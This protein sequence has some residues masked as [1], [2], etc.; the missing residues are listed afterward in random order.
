MTTQD[1][2]QTPT[3]YEIQH[4]A[5]VALA[6]GYPLVRGEL[7]IK[8]PNMRGCRF[9][10]VV[11]DSDGTMMFTVE[12]KR[13]PKATHHSKKAYY[14]QMAGVPNVFIAGWEQAL[15]ACDVVYKQLVNGS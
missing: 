1:F 8:R 7:I 9:D 13:N 2:K 5:H 14:E 3:E 15:N 11:F 6:K 4:L 12:V 10:L